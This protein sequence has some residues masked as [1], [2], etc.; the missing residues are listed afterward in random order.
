MEV[1]STSIVRYSDLIDTLWGNMVNQAQNIDTYK[2]GV[3]EYLKYPYTDSQAI[4]VSNGKTPTITWVNNNNCA[5]VTLADF[6][7]DY[8]N[9]MTSQLLQLDVNKYSVVKAPL[10]IKLI[11]A[12]YC[13]ITARFIWVFH[14]RY[15]QSKLFVNLS[16]QATVSTTNIVN[17]S[18]INLDSG[19]A[20]TII[21][22]IC[23]QAKSGVRSLMVTNSYTTSTN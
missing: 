14:P 17:L 11:T 6:Q 7:T 9:F 19:S 21:D 8:Q 13:Y 2:S 5:V 3:P 10:L 20:Q 12:M 23:N 18:T 4:Q 1:T 22:A 16:Q 15:D